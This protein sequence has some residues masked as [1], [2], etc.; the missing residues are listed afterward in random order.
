[1]SGGYCTVCPGKCAWHKHI[2]SHTYYVPEQETITV[3]LDDIKAKYD[4]NKTQLKSSTIV[5]LNNVD[6]LVDN[7]N[8]LVSC[9][10][11]I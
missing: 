4:N 6:E 3:N 10:I 8:K 7:C 1:M 2:N 11:K 5:I 9:H